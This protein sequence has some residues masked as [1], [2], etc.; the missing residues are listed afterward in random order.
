M[1]LSRLRNRI[2]DPRCS[3]PP[4]AKR[5]RMRL[6]PE[7]L[8]DR[9][10]PSNYIAASVSDLIADINASNQTGG[11]NTIL[12]AP[13][14]TFDVTAV[15]NTTNGAN[16]LPVIAKNDNLTVTGQGGDILQRDP[17]APAFRLFDVASGGTLMLNYLTL[18]TV[19]RP[20]PAARPKAGPST[21]RAA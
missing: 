12:L 2:P 1:W 17:G 19:M 5:R 4:A 14:T 10:L 8:E 9:T 16:G 7:R 21:T 3:R 18:N 15:N 20:A 13:K 6:S 11:S